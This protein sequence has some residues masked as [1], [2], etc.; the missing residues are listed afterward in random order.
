M[1]PQSHPRGKGRGK[2]VVGLVTGQKA[3]LRDLTTAIFLPQ[4]I[5]RIANVQE[6]SNPQA[7]SPRFELGIYY[8]TQDSSDLV[9]SAPLFK[10]GK[11]SE[12]FEAGTGRSLV[13]GSSSR[14]ACT[15][16]ASDPGRFEQFGPLLIGLVQQE[17]FQALQKAAIPSNQE[18]RR[19]L[20]GVA[21]YSKL[22]FHSIQAGESRSVVTS[23]SVPH[24]SSKAVQSRSDPSLLQL[25]SGSLAFRLQL[26]VQ[27][28]KCG[29]SAGSSGVDLEENLCICQK[30]RIS[31]WRAMSEY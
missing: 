30:F 28:G 13:G 6:G 4:L 5:F 3:P 29:G 14:V 19:F 1:W 9:V 23:L 7:S 8:F 25:G 26:H 27:S 31:K 16:F 18:E 15:W 24:R 10:P 12:R 21:R 2:V 22:L 11:L 20:L 17:L